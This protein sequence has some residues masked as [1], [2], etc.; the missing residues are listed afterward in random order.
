MSENFAM[1]A[2]DSDVEGL[3][4]ATN[5]LDNI[6]NRPLT[7]PT[8]DHIRGTKNRLNDHIVSIIQQSDHISPE[9]LVRMLH[10]LAVGS[11][12]KKILEQAAALI[13]DKC[14]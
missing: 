3:D 4:E 9:L 8:Q 13:A 2:L 6:L 5:H 14:C 7:A 11:V 1:D 12:N 10:H